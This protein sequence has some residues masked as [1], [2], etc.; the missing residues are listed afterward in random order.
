VKEEEKEVTSEVDVAT[1]VKEV[2]ENTE[3]EENIEV[4]EV[5]EDLTPAT[6]EMDLMMKVSRLSSLLEKEAEAKEE[7]A[8]EVI[9]EEK[10]ETG[11][12]EEKEV[13]SEEELTEAL[14]EVLIEVVVE[15]EVKDHQ[16]KDKPTMRLQLE[17]CQALPLLYLNQLPLRSER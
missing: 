9:E 1:T 3:V 2:E 8:K 11:E 4:E 14:I 6:K 15:A 13:N 16:E 10:E 17:T 5:E 7:E 12:V